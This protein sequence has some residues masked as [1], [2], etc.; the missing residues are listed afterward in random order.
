LERLS[1]LHLA[2]ETASFERAQSS[3]NPDTFRFELG[4][5]FVEEW[6]RGRR[7]SG[8]L[9]EKLVSSV[10]DAS[11][12]ATTREQNVAIQRIL[13]SFDFA[14]SGTPYRS[15]KGDCKLVLYTRSK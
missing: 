2:I 9:V 14:I 10:G 5:L 6:H 4:W 13:K 12:Y 1:D 11:V 15:A 8:V 7:L 3:L